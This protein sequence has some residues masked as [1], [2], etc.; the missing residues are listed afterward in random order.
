YW[1]AAAP[2]GLMVPDGIAAPVIRPAPPVRE[3]SLMRLSWL[4]FAVV[5]VAV[6]VGPARAGD[7]LE[8]AKT[9]AVIA[10]VL[11]WQSQSLTAFSTKHRKDEE[12]RNV[13]RDR[14]VPEDH[15]TLL[16]DQEATRA[17][18]WAAVRAA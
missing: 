11:Q 16:L 10:G 17:R 18:I 9:Y 1:T 4:S 12:L 6:S 5:A 7:E 3:V 15:L 14:G 8:P 13:L 2:N